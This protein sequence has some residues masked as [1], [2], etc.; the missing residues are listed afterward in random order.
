MAVACRD[1]GPGLRCSPDPARPWAPP[2]ESA[3]HLLC[4]ERGPTAPSALFP[5]TGD[6]PPTPMAE[7]K[8]ERDP[9]NISALDLRPGKQQPSVSLEWVAPQLVRINQ[10]MPC[11]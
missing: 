8:V 5:R 10:P 11:Q 3:G 9:V 6:V 7:P 2:W 4:A 1:A